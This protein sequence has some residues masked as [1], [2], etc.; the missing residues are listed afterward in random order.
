M[1]HGHIVD[2]R[3]E[4]GINVSGTAYILKEICKARFNG[5]YEDKASFWGAF[6]KSWSHN[7]SPKCS[8]S[9]NAI[10]WWYHGLRI[11]V[12]SL[13]WVSHVRG[14]LW[15]RY[16]VRIFS[17]RET[18]PFPIRKQLPKMVKLRTSLL[19]LL[20]HYW[21]SGN[22]EITKS[23]FSQIDSSVIKGTMDILYL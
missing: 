20:S 17:A 5:T 1:N 2:Y 16:S 11:Q 7:L 3:A 21:F 13:K 8:W 14:T 4:L 12:V 10:L 15:D 22:E 19:V 6:R 9:T 18:G 23:H